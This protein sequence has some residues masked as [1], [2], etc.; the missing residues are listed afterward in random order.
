[1]W[2]TVCDDGWDLS[3]ARVVCRQ[4]GFPDATLSSTG[5]SFGEG[6]G[7]IWMDDV[8]CSGDEARLEDCTFSGWGVNNCDHTK[9]SGVI[10]SKMPPTPACGL[11]V[12]LVN[13]G[14]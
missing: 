8:E 14:I 12:C 7:S 9:D 4:L 3:D 6:N 10:C 5:S 1:M 2:G 11:S 13:C